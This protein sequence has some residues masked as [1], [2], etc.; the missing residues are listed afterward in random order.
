MSGGQIKNNQIS[1]SS[2][3]DNEALPFAGRLNAVAVRRSGGWVA[4]VNDSNQWFQVYYLGFFRGKL[5]LLYL[6]PNC[7]E[8]LVDNIYQVI[9]F[10][11]GRQGRPL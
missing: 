2:M 5:C 6:Y 4:G 3:Y 8:Q 7:R 1:A 9:I 10:C 11:P